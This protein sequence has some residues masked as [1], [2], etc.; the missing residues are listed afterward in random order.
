MDAL[1]V[2]REVVPVTEFHLMLYGDAARRSK[3]L[4]ASQ[5]LALSEAV[6]DSMFQLPTPNI[7]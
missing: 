6:M 7:R 3:V 2:S 4:A 1:G 5:G